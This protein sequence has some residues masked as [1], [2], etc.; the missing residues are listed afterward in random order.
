MY[1]K[2]DFKSDFK[3]NDRMAS[4]EASYVDDC[5]DDYVDYHVVVD[6]C[7]DDCTAGYSNQCADDHSESYLSEWAEINNGYG[8]NFVSY[9]KVKKTREQYQN[10]T[11]FGKDYIRGLLKT[12][13]QIH[14]IGKYI[15]VKNLKIKFEKKYV[16]IE[17][18]K[19]SYPHL[20]EIFNHSAD[21]IEIFALLH[22]HRKDRNPG[23]KEKDFKCTEDSEIIKI[24]KNS[25]VLFVYE[26]DAYKCFV[27]FR[28]DTVLMQSK[29]SDFVDTIPVS[30]TAIQ[31]RIKLREN[32]ICSDAL[33]FLTIKEWGTG[34]NANPVARFANHRLFDKNVLCIIK[35]MAGKTSRY[36]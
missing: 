12:K 1:A 35:E 22:E 18:M 23:K 10:S 16:I 15:H 5:V 3:S 14:V 20:L 19:V 25:D 21:P 2:S 31:D 36:A 26:N 24:H 9:A 34:N 11:M 4:Q 7:V 27:N 32:E 6:D 8:A 17:D 13:Y 33:L 30:R 28:D 29:K